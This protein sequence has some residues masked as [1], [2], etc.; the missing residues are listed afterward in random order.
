MSSGK[1]MGKAVAVLTS[2]GVESGALI[3]EALRAYERV[4]PVYIQKGLR[5]EKAERAALKTFLSAMKQDGLAGVTVLEVPLKTIYGRHWS[6][7]SEKTPGFKAPDT[8][9]YLPGRNLLLLSLAGLFCSVRKI[10]VLWLGVLKGNPFHDA[11]TGFL[12]QMEGLLEEVLGSHLRIAAPFREL[13]KGQV[14]GRWPGLPWGKTFSCLQP[15]GGRHCGRC[16]KC[17]ERKS[18]FRNA[19]ISDPTGYKSGGTR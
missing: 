2:G 14:I 13:T 16:Q 12:Q 17:A 3:A 10:P 5:W 7:G 11:R 15:F 9:V 6:L 19:G 18:G 4:Y 1:G 8:A